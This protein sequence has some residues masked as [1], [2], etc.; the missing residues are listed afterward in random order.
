MADP[1]ATALAVLMQAAGAVAVT[2]LPAAGGS[3]ATQAIRDTHS[4]E[5]H[6][7]FAST[8]RDGDQIT[9]AIGAIPEPVTGDRIVIGTDI[10]RVLAAPV[11]D[12]ERLSW[13]IQAAV[14][15]N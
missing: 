5:S 3:Y 10:L 2:Y 1:F 12:A 9:I 11:M 13:I 14:D 8:L 15:P 4:A 7:A 6:H